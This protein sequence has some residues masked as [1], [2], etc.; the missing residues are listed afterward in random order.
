MLFALIGLLKADADGRLPD[1]GT[2]NEHLA[3]PFRRTR[4]AGYLCHEGGA[5]IGMM[6]LLEADDFAAAQSFLHQSPFFK[7]DLYDKVEVA[8]YALEVGRLD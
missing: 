6:M 7:A 4:L 1:S 5:R 8:E 2:I 3:Q